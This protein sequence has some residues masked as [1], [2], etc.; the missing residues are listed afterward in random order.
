MNEPVFNRADAVTR[1]LELVPRVG[2]TQAV[3]GVAA[4]HGV[5]THAIKQAIV[6]SA[7]REYLHAVGLTHEPA[8]SVVIAAAA[9]YRL[10]TDELQSAIDE[11]LLSMELL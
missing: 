5:S 2:W 3:A 11:H 10:T 4:R 7:V 6:A 9:K 8:C 1:F